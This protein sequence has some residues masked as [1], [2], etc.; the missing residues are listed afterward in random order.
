MKSRQQRRKRTCDAD[1]EPIADNV[2]LRV[3]RNDRALVPM[4]AER[5]R[6]LR[7]HL[8]ETLLAWHRVQDLG[9]MASPLPPAF[10]GFTAQVA[11]TACA[12]CQGWCCKGG[13]EHAYLDERVIARVSQ[14]MPELGRWSILRMY[15]ARVPP[16][17][18][19]GS[20]VFHGERGCTLDRSLRSDV[21]NNYFCGGLGSFVTRGEPA[22]PVVV[23]A[24]EG[25]QMRK[26][27]VLRP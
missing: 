1:G 6:R 10:D 20:C 26:S 8:L 16:S 2:T 13:G 7:K 23:I 22:E 17:G 21:C 14:A 5:V 24:G 19:H 27:P 3:P 15:L 11:Q 12:L 9:G 25:E 18:Y 4:T